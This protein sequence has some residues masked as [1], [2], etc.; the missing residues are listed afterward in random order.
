MDVSSGLSG[1]A[2][3]PSRRSV[4]FLTSTHSAVRGQEEHTPGAA[5]GNISVL[6]HDPDMGVVQRNRASSQ[7]SQIPFYP[8][9]LSRSSGRRYLCSEGGPMQEERGR[10]SKE[11]ALKHTRLPLA[12]AVHNVTRQ[13]G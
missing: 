2:R 8:A 7:C 13:S 12:F 9:L 10:L 11:L 3:T 4:W 5:G 6:S 1:A